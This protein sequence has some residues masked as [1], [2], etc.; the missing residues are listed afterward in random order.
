[1][2][3]VASEIKQALK[4]A[5]PG[6]DAHAKL[7]PLRPEV[8]LNAL[9]T[10]PNP[11]LSAVMIL[12]WKEDKELFTSLILRNSYKGVHSAQIAFPGGK[13][14]DSDPDLITTALRETHEEIGVAGIEVIGALSN[15]YIPPSGFMVSPYIGY[16]NDAPSFVPDPTE[17]AEVFKVPVSMIMEPNTIKKKAI[18]MADRLMIKAPY[19]DIH[20]QVVWG[21]TAMILNEFKEVLL[22][23]N[24][25]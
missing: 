3:T 5:L 17:V 21:A 2:L 25:F 6:E 9:K 24:I 19:F 23:T 18:P 1:M 15:I 7:A 8:R 20:G 16:I 11:K 12:L 10:N 4:Q 14:E 13:K 22:R